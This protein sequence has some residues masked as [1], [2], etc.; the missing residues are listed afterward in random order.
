MLP[1]IALYYDKEDLEED[2]ET[3]ALFD[4]KENSR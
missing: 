3:L 4:E 1:T 2:L